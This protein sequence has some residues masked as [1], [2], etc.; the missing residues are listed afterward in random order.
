MFFTKTLLI[1]YIMSSWWLFEKKKFNVFFKITQKILRKLKFWGYI[2]G[3]KSW[4]LQLWSSRPIPK[5]QR[6]VVKITFFWFFAQNFELKFVLWKKLQ[7][8]VNFYNW[9]WC[10]NPRSTISVGGVIFEKFLE[11]GENSKFWIFCSKFRAKINF[12]KNLTLKCT[13]F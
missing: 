10:K 4:D 9:I 12:S 1:S 13:F 5:N 8:N 7:W 6:K 2:S 3:A 11:M